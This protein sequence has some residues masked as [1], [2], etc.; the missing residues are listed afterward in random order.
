MG[1]YDKKGNKGD[2]VI[3]TRARLAR[4]LRGFN[5]PGAMTA[6]QSQ[7][8]INM[9]LEA[10][11]PVLAGYKVYN[12]W[13]MSEREIGLLVEKR[14]ISPNFP[15]G[16]LKKTA[17]VSE[18]ESICIMINEEDHIRIQCFSSGLEDKQVLDTCT[19]IERL[20]AETLSFAFD[21]RY[22]YLTACPTNCGTALRLSAMVHLPAL[23]LAGAQPQ[24]L[25][26]SAKQGMTVRGVY[27]E[28]SEAPGSIYQIS[29]QITLGLSV[30]EIAELFSSMIDMIIKAEGQM[31]DKI[32][33]GAAPK[34][35]DEI[36]RALG[37]LKNAYMISGTEYLNLQSLVR[38]GVYMGKLHADTEKLTRLW[39]E[40]SPY[41]IGID[42]SEQ[43]DIKRAE[44]I[45][46]E[47]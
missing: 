4:N 20:L 38:L 15:T 22:G 27:G 39:I 28:G 5:F 8:V 47:L 6:E 42:N 43:R 3:S 25:R 37:T 23:D 40:A 12:I 32:A 17:L 18:D 2:F 1:W 41:H 45:R 46:R 16:A 29:N 36:Y 21:E 7:T 26:E 24:L 19:K 9:V 31:R 13:E 44:I 34:M 11:K 14:L 30:Q 35:L 10:M 33:G